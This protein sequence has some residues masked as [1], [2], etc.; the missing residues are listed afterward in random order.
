M[1]GRKPTNVELKHD[2]KLYFESSYGN[3]F[4]DVPGQKA[5][6]LNKDGRKDNVVIGLGS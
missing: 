4:Q 5:E 1:E 6:I 3:H 2:N